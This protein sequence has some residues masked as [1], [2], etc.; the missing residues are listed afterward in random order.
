MPIVSWI[1]MFTFL[2]ETTESIG[3][4]LRRIGPPMFMVSIEK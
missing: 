4:T 3:D 2:Q 1:I